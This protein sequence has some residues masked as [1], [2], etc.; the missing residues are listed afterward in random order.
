MQ[1]FYSLLLWNSFS[2]LIPPSAPAAAQKAAAA[3][4]LGFR[5]FT[6]TGKALVF[7]TAVSGAF[8]AGLDAGLTYNS[9]PLMAG[10]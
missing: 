7:L 1:V 4:I 2:V 8:V 10:R 9:F 6:M 3:S 5:R